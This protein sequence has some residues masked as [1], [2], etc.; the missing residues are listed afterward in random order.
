MPSNGLFSELR[1][2]NVFKVA[3]AY[4][5]LSWLLIQVTDALFPALN[6]PDWSVTFVVGLLIIGFIPA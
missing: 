4:L 5:V 6:M 2:R 3:I 1:R